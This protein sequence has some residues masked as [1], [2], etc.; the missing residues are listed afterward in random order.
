MINWGSCR[1]ISLEICKYVFTL[2][3]LLPYFILFSNLRKFLIQKSIYKL[4][5]YVCNIA[6]NCVTSS[7]W[8]FV[9]YP[10]VL[11]A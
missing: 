3:V 5:F 9:V 7:W 10:S 1:N 4:L 2:I 6:D 11:N 8:Q